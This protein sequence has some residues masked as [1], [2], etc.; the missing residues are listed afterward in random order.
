MRRRA[1]LWI[2]Y[3]DKTRTSNRIHIIC[4][5][6]LPD[7]FFSL[8]YLVYLYL[9]NRQHILFQRGL[10]DEAILFISSLSS[11]KN[12]KISGKIKQLERYI[13]FQINAD[14]VSS[15]YFSNI[16]YSSAVKAC[17]TNRPLLLIIEVIISLYSEVLS[18]LAYACITHEVK[19]VSITCIHQPKGLYYFHHVDSLWWRNSTNNWIW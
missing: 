5:S 4:I 12:N 17:T 3:A 11:S 1:P 15:I 6:C 2:C 14:T 9:Y 8:D 18:F 13:L 19:E 16:N 7:D 10:L